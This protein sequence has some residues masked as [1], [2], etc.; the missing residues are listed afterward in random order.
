MNNNQAN[1]EFQ[2]AILKALYKSEEISEKKY[3]YALNKLQLKLEK[4]KVEYDELT[5]IE[6]KI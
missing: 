1:I 6:I 3:I 2:L 4:T 5:E